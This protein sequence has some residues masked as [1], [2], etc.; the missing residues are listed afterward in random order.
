MRSTVWWGMAVLCAIGVCY[1]LCRDVLAAVLEPV[2]QS[3]G[4]EA[5]DARAGL[6][7]TLMFA[8]QAVVSLPLG[9]AGDRLSRKALLAGG[10]FVWGLATVGAGLARS[11]P[12]LLLARC[13][14]GAGQACGAVLLPGLVA[15]LF[16]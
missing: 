5:Q 4:L 16:L 15:D 9:L 14:L 10:A 12:H 1:Y 6:L 2:Q 11:F 13:L 3:V 8:S 7:S